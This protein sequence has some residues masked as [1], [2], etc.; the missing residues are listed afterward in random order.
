MHEVFNTKFFQ[1][2]SED[3]KFVAEGGNIEKPSILLVLSWVKN[4]WNDI[5]E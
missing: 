4:A 5:P 2:I 1:G 3:D